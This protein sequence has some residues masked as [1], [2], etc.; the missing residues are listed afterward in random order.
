MSGECLKICPR[1]AIIV[2]EDRAF[3][4]R[5]KCN[6]EGLCMSVCPNK[7]IVALEIGEGKGGR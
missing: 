5:E 7:A 4:I 2:R 6:L 3:I 1:D